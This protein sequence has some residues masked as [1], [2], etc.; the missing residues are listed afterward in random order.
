MDPRWKY[1]DSGCFC[2]VRRPV[3]PLGSFYE[4]FA[5]RDRFPLILFTVDCRLEDEQMNLQVLLDLPSDKDI[6]SS[7]EIRVKENPGLVK[8]TIRYRNGIVATILKDFH[9]TVFSVSLDTTNAPFWLRRNQ[10][11]RMS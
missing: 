10:V 5:F 1:L 6:E 4:P 7:A 2:K 11:L 9:D 8:K 3:S